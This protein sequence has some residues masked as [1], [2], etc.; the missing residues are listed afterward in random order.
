MPTRRAAWLALAC[1][2][3]GVHLVAGAHNDAVM[4]GLL[5]LGLLVLVRRPGRPRALVVRR[6][7]CSGWR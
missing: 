4:L 1:P 6:G 5:L 7:C 2:L 3:V